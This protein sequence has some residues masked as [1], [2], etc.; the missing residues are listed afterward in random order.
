MKTNVIPIG[1]FGKVTLP[2]VLGI[3][4]WFVIALL[5]VAAILLF[6]FFERKNL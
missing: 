1:D 6:R 5:A 4:H 2:Q 3:S